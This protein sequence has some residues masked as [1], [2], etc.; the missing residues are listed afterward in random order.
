MCISYIELIRLNK[1]LLQTVG[2]FSSGCC[3]PDKPCLVFDTHV[4]GLVQDY[5]NP[6][7][8]AVGLL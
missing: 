6:S 7:V 2:N 5:S 1:G 4:D 3:Q 8:L